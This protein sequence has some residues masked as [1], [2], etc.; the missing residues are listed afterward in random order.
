MTSRANDSHTQEE[1][2]AQEALTTKLL[3]LFLLLLM[4]VVGFFVDIKH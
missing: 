2:E 4:S 1:G 3:F